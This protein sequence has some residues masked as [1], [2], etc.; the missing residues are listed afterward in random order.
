MPLRIEDK[1]IVVEELHEIANKA[2]SA[3]VADYHGT[4]VSELTELREN[5]RNSSVY[6]KVIKNTLARKALT[7]T[8]FSCLDELL[9][10]PTVLAFSLDDPANAAKLANNF[11]KVNSNFK[12]KGLSMGET[13]L[14]LSR[15]SDI[16][17]LPS[18]DEALAKLAGLLKA[19][20]VKLASLMN[21]IPTKLTITLEAIKQQKQQAES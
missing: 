16:A 18:K 9:V 21:E 15:L 1:K 13:L 19:P 4:T 10:G 20:L 11:H 7:D 6:L 3:I 8:K 17:N 5:A 2:S 14:E 12:V